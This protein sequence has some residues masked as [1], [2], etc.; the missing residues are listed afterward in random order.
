MVPT[1]ELAFQ[2][3]IETKSFCK[4]MDL[5]CVCVY[6]GAGVGNQLSDLRR[7]AEIVICTPGRMIDVLCLSNG[8]ITNLRRVTYVVIDEADRLFDMGFEPQIARILANIRPDR[9]TVLFSA[10]FPKQIES[11]AK[12]ILIKPIEIVVGTRGQSCVNVEQCVEVRDESTK[13]YRLLEILGEY[14]S[15]NTSILIFV[16]KQVEAD[17]LFK[18]LFKLGYYCLVIHGGQDQEDRDYA[19]S[20]FKSGVRNILIATSVCARGL[21][22]KHCGLVINF[23]CP[24]HMEDYVHR[25]G[26]TGRAGNKGFAYTFISPE[27]GHQAEDI[28]RSLEL[29]NQ[30]LPE[31]LRNLVRSYKEKLDNGEVDKYRT[32][33]FYGRGFKFNDNE[34]DK[35]KQIRKELGKTY[36]VNNNESDSEDEPEIK[37]GDPNSAENGPEKTNA[38]TKVK[39]DEKKK[40]L[41]GLFKDPK[42]KQLAMDAGM[43]AAKNSIIAGKSEEQALMI[44]QEAIEKVIQEYRPSVSTEKGVEQA[45]KIIEDWV[46]KENE[47]N[48]IFTAELEIND[49]PTAARSRVCGREFISSIYEM[50]GCNVCVR[51]N[52]VESGKKVPSGMKKLHLYIQGSTKIEV[53][54]AYKEIKR[55]LDENALQYYTMGNNNGYTGN[56]GRYQI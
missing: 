28:L 37:G 40:K 22:V 1:R 10:T 42:A 30:K 18:E 50:T 17:E 44:A 32:N 14:S 39:D 25:V 13:F 51:G 43:M 33:G 12:K 19:I 55:I 4:L 48:N 45:S 2:I 26:R 21:D 31:E 16:D 56:S 34:K 27:E 20:D 11:L 24:N 38:I 54:S 41:L 5:S 29:S 49:Y 35:I 36:G 53:S 23:K 15:K 52:Y 3:Y 8:K 6:G 9:Q 7:G 47:K 46:D